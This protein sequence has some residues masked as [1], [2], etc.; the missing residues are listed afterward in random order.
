MRGKETFR[1][2]AASIIVAERKEVSQ[3][4]KTDNAS[5]LYDTCMRIDLEVYLADIRR[6]C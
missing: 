3:I 5:H 6:I 1:D 4:Y 2:R